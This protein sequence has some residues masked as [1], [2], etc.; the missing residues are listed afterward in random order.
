[1]RRFSAGAVAT[2]ALWKSI[3]RR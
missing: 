2:I 3:G 1:M